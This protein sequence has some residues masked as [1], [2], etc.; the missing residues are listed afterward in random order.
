MTDTQSA[1]A[2]DSA[3]ADEAATL[4]PTARVADT[5]PPGRRYELQEEIARGAMGV[6]YRAVDTTLGRQVAVKVLQDR[7]GPDSPTARRF[8]GEARIAGQLQHPGIP[9]VHD[10]GTLPDGR[11]F[12]AMRLVKGRT[13]DELLE[14]PE[15]GSPSLVAIFE[16]VCQAVGYAHAHGVIHRDLKPANVMVGAFGEVQVMDWGLA[17]VLGPVAGPGDTTGADETTAALTA[18]DSERDDGDM[19][20]AGSVLGTPAYMPPEQA[21]GAVNQVN[22]RSDVFGLG[23]ILCAVLTGKP[24]FLRTDLEST[25]QQ[26]ARAKL[27]DAFSRLDRCG[28]ERELVALC[29][30]CLSPEQAD[31]PADAGEVARAVAEL[32]SA[33]EERA[34]L[35]Q[36]DRVRAEAEAREQRKRRRVQ[37]ALIAAVGLLLAFAWYADRQATQRRA[38]ADRRDRD[39]QARLTRNAD[40]LAELTGQCEA[41]LRAG[42]ADRAAAALE[43][44]DRRLP[45]GG[46]DT[47]WDRTE[48]C[49]AGLAVLH[50]L[51]AIDT[52]RWTPIGN[53][54]GVE[55]VRSARL[56]A[57]LARHGIALGA[58]PAAEAAALV[59]GSPVRDRL[60]TALDLWLAFVPSKAVRDVL[61]AA[62]PEPYRDAVRDAAAARGWNR[63]ADLAGR[64]EA[65]DQPPRFAAVLGQH[66]V[67]SAERRRKVLNA[68]LRSRPGDLSL[69]MALGESYPYDRREG[70]D[71]RARW[72]QAA[73]AV[74]PRSVAAH[75]NLA[76]ALRHKGDLEGA[77]ESHRE[78]IRLDPTFGP[79]HNNLGLALRTK[80]D[81]DGAVACFREA[82]RLDPAEPTIHWNLATTLRS[83]GDWVAA[84]GSYNDAIRFAL[85]REKERPSPQTRP[86]TADTVASLED[87]VRLGPQDA[88]AHNDLARALATRPDGV[89]DGR[90][91]VEHA[92]RACQLTGWVEAEYIDTLA[93]AY[94]E[95]GDFGKAVEY[96]KRAL[97]FPQFEATH[98]KGGR[99]RLGLYAQKKP[100]REPAVPR[101]GK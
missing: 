10:L 18:I 53:S 67:V 3:G 75:I 96:Q 50:E 4:S 92:A 55:R 57:A 62:D 52:L 71:E 8:A 43:Q 48:R 98:G 56:P 33:S 27:D 69:L 12:L 51:D 68:A 25:R 97:S 79:G 36:F 59:S 38:D 7:F 16:Q 85:V 91:A 86:A 99:E 49:R 23:A 61:R 65:L 90:R 6:V 66:P 89:R 88:K 35:A 5:P 22:A 11:P 63:F 80:G 32:R 37:L 40:A 45:D 60:L 95:A 29:K 58:M 78:V 42:D 1:P 44:V 20:R 54:P 24:P 41:A 9:A 17:K 87:A 84:I 72:F 101:D 31:R 77:I 26:A 28:S 94:A 39:E 13:L 76:D 47:V 100:Y 21:I 2:G 83:K 14:E 81:L 73:T 19:T 93:A 82:A 34:R 70:A 15:P 74:H 64:P 30:R 46:G